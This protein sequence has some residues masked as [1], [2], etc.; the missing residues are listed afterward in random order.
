MPDRD[1]DA[2]GWVVRMDEPGW[3]AVDDAALEAWL[4]ADPKRSGALLK[5]QALWVAFDHR[6]ADSM[7]SRADAEETLDDAKSGSLPSRRWLLGSG[8]A[9]AACVAGGFLLFAGT[10][11]ET[12]IGEIRRIPLADGTLAS[13]NTDSAVAVE[14]AETSRRVTLTKGE[15]W[16]Q[17]AKDRNRPFT[18]AAGRIRAQAIGTAFS[19]RRRENGADIMVTEGVVLAWADGAE[20]NRI[21]LN[22]GE[23]AFIADNAAVQLSPAGAPAVDR[24]LAWRA[25]KIDLVSMPLGVAAAE[26]NRYNHRQI[27]IA[28]PALRLEQLDGVFGTNDPETFAAAVRDGLSVPIDLDDPAR[29]RIGRLPR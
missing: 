1:D 2:A 16:F 21:R 28:D 9:V 3:S 22:A 20:G 7:P 17:V 23:S 18:V 27:E 14:L 29:I 19:V 24:A 11:Y 6:V 4:A 25:G 15:V 12:A 13:I 8:A 10:R 26:F 5:A